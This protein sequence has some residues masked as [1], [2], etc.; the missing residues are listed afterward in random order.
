METRH[1]IEEAVF[2]IVFDSKTEVLEQQTDLGAFAR[3]CL[4]PVVEAVFDELSGDDEVMCIER[5]EIDLGTVAYD[6]FQ[7]ALA[8]RLRERLTAVLQARLHSFAAGV[9][10]RE[11]IVSR[12]RRE[13]EQLQQFLL[14]GYLP[15]PAGAE[16]SIEQ[17]LRHT[18]GSDERARFIAFLRRPGSRDRVLQR[19]VRQFPERDLAAVL[20]ALAPDLGEGAPAAFAGM[21]AQAR[22]QDWVMLFDALLRGDGEW[23]R[24]G[25]LLERIRREV[26]AAEP[27]AQSPHATAAWRQR[28]EA[29]MAVGDAS[30]LGA[31]WPELVREQPALV[32][33]VLRDCGRRAEVRRC[34]ARGFPEPLLRDLVVLLEP[35]ESGFIQEVVE[36]PALFRQTHGDDP[37]EPGGRKR[38]LWEFTLT[39]LLVERGGRFNKQSYLGSVVRQ[40]AAHDNLNARDLL[41]SLIDVLAAAEIPSRLKNEMLELLGGLADAPGSPAEAG[42]RQVIHGYDFYA[43]PQ[44]E[45]ALAEILESGGEI[46]AAPAEQLAAVLEYMLARRPEGLRR[47]LPALLEGREAARRLA[48]WL[49]ERLLTRLLHLLRPAEHE[50]AQRCADAIAVAACASGGA[51][52]AE[53]IQQ[54]KWQFLFRYLFEEGRPFAQADFARGLADYLAEQ[55]GRRDAGAFRGLLCRELAR[56]ALPS[57]RERHR[58]IAVALAPDEQAVPRTRNRDAVEAQDGT[59][60]IYIDNAGQ[61]LAAPYLPRLFAVLALTE[62]GVF[63]DRQAA[64]RGAHLLQFLVDERADAPEHQLVLNKILCGVRIG[65]PIVRAIAVSEQEKEAI[66][67][68]IRAM[69]QHWKVIGNTSVA[70]LRESFLQRPGMLRR[71]DDA[72]H[73][74][75]QDRAFDLLLDRLPWSF[76]TI[77]HAWM[78]EVVHVDWR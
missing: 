78:E 19:L 61:V 50:G 10:G 55:T 71:K 69:I 12:Q 37:Q 52:A 54:L 47:S 2:E 68:L 7:Q 1:R 28:L 26:T 40:M 70:G 33:A 73:L 29:A 51:G 21:D 77:K 9:Q 13:R 11:G 25:P 58:A 57:T 43:E 35:T 6:G 65:T 66:E 56:T 20:S 76:S 16:Q 14:R 15:W 31:I 72:W 3:R 34:I 48:A 42:S 64:E 38:R 75:V 18:L 23:G 62:Q 27:A 24:A 8:W 67:G 53:R 46:P 74:Q 41:A 45:D 44:A 59:E 49:P 39:Y 17:M 60:T 5:L 22:R 30:D 4:L 36:R 32:V 63:K